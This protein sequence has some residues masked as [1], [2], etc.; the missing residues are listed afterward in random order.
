[1]VQDGTSP[2]PPQYV[3]WCT[4]S[5]SSIQEKLKNCE[6]ASAQLT[7]YFRC[8]RE[9][10]P[11]GPGSMI[12]ASAPGLRALGL[13][14]LG[15]RALGLRALGLRAFGLRALGLRAL[16]V[17]IAFRATPMSS[18]GS[19]SSPAQPDIVNTAI[20]SRDTV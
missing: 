9:R 19:F 1:M 5:A 7:L 16:S 12:A 13:R 4:T 14:A 6:G 2:R 8:C 11:A 18:S 10:S 17:S 15:L 3:S 20:V